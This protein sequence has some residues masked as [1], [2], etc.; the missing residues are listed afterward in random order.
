MNWEAM[1]NEDRLLA[2][3]E[4]LEDQLMLCANKN[5][6]PA[7]LKEKIDNYFEQRKSVE[8]MTKD[9]L[10]KSN[11]EASEARQRL[12]EVEVALMNVEDHNTLLKKQT[13]D[14]ERELGDSKYELEK[15]S[16]DYDVVCH[17]LELS[18]ATNQHLLLTQKNQVNQVEDASPAV[19]SDEITVAPDDNTGADENKEPIPELAPIESF[20]S[21][22]NNGMFHVLPRIYSCLSVTLPSF[23][24]LLENE[25]PS[26]ICT[27][28]SDELKRTYTFLC[29]SFKKNLSS[30]EAIFV[31]ETIAKSIAKAA[32]MTKNSV[33]AELLKDTDRNNISNER[34]ENGVSADGS[35]SYDAKSEVRQRPNR[36][37]SDRND[38]AVQKFRVDDSKVSVFCSFGCFNGFLQE[39]L[40]SV[41]P[42]FSM[43]I[44]LISLVNM[45]FLWAVKKVTSKK[46]S[47]GKTG[48]LK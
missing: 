35:T 12:H 32:T 36:S 29:K 47:V 38:F 37:A 23:E 3:I 48:D 45:S 39:N 26:D 15:L 30:E 20:N 4:V 19:A 33:T 28:V 31:Q 17:E 41:L 21:I 10:R 1:I 9:L 44:L 25:V 42:L 11:Q 46:E 6:T 5:L 13:N 40:F 14:L 18:K 43:F 34:H 8:T 22:E 24:S 16:G 2:R 7:E 27:A